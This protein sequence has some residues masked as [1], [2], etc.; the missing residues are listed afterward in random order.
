MD[1]FE[2]TALIFDGI[3][4]EMPRLLEATDWS[5]TPLGPTSSWSPVL[6]VLVPTMLRSGLPMVIN[7]GPEMVALY[8]DAY[9]PLLGHKHPLAVGQATKDTWP[10]AWEWVAPRLEQILLGGRTV[11]LE[12]ERQILERNGYPEE[13][14]FTFSQSPIID[15]DGGIGG[16]LT[17][18]TETTSAILSERRMRVV[19]DLGALSAV[20]IAAAAQVTDTERTGSVAVA[21]GAALHVL[22][23]ARESVPFAIAFVG[24]EGAATVA[25]P[26]AVADYGLLSGVS[27]GSAACGS[28]A[29]FATWT[30]VAA[31]VVRTGVP[32]VLTGVRTR[33]VGV[34]EPSPLGPLH[35]DTAVMMPM[36]VNGRAEPVGAL[37]FG[38]NP[39]RLWDEDYRAFLSLVMRQLTIVLTD[40]IAHDTDRHRLRA[41]ADLDRAKTEF[42]QNVSHELRTPLTLLLAPLRGILDSGDIGSGAHR[43]DLQ[44][45]LRAAE[46]LRVMVDALLDFSTVRA[47]VRTADRR[48]TE[49]KVVTVETASMFRA[50]ATQGGLDY[51]VTMPEASLIAVVDGPIW[52]TIV[53]NLI[54]NALKYTAAGAIEIRLRREDTDAVL[55]VTDTGV[56]ISP[57]QQANV[58]ERFHRATPEQATPGAGIG[59]ALVIDLVR[60]LHGRVDLSSEPGVG[61]TVTVAVPLAQ[62]PS[63]LLD[64]PL[65]VESVDGASTTAGRVMVVED[66]DDLRR[67]LTRL[68]SRDGWAVT[69]V[70]DAETA[71]ATAIAEGGTPPDVILTDVMLAGRTGLQLVSDLRQAPA[72]SRLPVI[73]VTGRGGPDAAEEGLGAGADDYITKPFSAPELLARVRTNYE[74]HQLR[75][76]AVKIAQGRAEQIRRGLDSNRVIGTAIGIV[77]ATYRLTAEQAFRLLTTA[78][79]NTNSKL[80]D[81]AVAVTDTGTLPYRPADID[82]LLLRTLTSR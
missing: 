5:A 11:R 79:Q 2:P 67:Y 41:L 81:I 36:T 82:E 4:G 74:L 39:Y 21:C 17:V 69:A 29:E 20:D 72:T 31:K 32:E 56:G 16:I 63:S 48:P 14:Y 47:G 12:N 66:D 58:F 25:A 42:F 33:M 23:T 10:E 68:L 64:E 52:A 13:C 6:R 77:M 40:A 65:S 75:E 30:A 18:A 54:S 1:P 57:E 73:V 43:E 61:T 27:G 50:A 62:G 60:G 34:A 19:R 44:A 37:L 46:R 26:R 28:P 15:A 24:A 45:A 49:L 38:L 76:G 35:P 78:S 70:A 59:L 80:R 22:R 53:T 3:P 55:T 9:A 51:T 71:L 8:N 7:W